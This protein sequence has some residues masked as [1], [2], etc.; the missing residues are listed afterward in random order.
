MTFLACGSRGGDREQTS[1]PQVPIPCQA[2]A[3]A[4]CVP[5]TTHNEASISQQPDPEPMLCTPRPTCPCGSSHSYSRHVPVSAC[6]FSLNLLHNKGM[7]HDYNPISQVR[8]L[9]LQEVTYVA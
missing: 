6:G 3:K 8:K 2:P 9:K 4:V 1:G 7:G 5:Y